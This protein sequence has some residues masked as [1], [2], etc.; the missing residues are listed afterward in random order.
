MHLREL[1][2]PLRDLNLDGR[3]AASYRRED[4]LV[5]PRGLPL[6]RERG[7]A[8]GR[9]CYVSLLHVHG[10]QNACT[11][12]AVYERPQPPIA[13]TGVQYA[14]YHERHVMVC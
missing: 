1:V 12:C 4:F 6:A 8:E 11:A 14:D 3:G 2:R 13:A 7:K 10:E 9:D 5:R